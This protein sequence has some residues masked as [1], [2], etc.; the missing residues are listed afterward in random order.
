MK[1]LASFVVAV[2]LVSGCSAAHKGSPKSVVPTG[3]T[4]PTTGSSVPSEVPPC[5]GRVPTARSRAAG[6]A[7]ALVPFVATGVRVCRYLVV[8][9]SSAVY[10]A[11]SAKAGTAAI[12]ASLER[13]MNAFAVVRP[14]DLSIGC[15]ATGPPM[16]FVTFYGPASSVDA[17]EEGGCGEL[18]NGFRV[19]SA[20]RS[21][22]VEMAGWTKCRGCRPEAVTTVNG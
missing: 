10:L 11:G 18:T 7:T 19:V 15:P 5:P 9:N 13:E 14:Q 17:A 21:W 20:T 12:V 8:E 22:R 1:P 16:F 4:R 6:L 2:A 3:S